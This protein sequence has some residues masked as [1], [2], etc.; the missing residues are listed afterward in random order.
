[1]SA[2]QFTIGQA[3]IVS[4]PMTPCARHS[5]R[6]VRKAK[7]GWRVRFDA[8]G[9]M[10]TETMPESALMRAESVTPGQLA[11][12]ADVRARPLYHDGTPRRTWHELGTVER[13]SWER[14]PTGR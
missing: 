9:M 6:I 8:W 11:Y 12:E 5:G 3:V 7:H 14:N 10:I 4:P 1:M 13:W 2:P